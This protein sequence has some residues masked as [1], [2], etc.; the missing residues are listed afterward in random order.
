MSWIFPESKRSL[1]GKRWLNITMRSFH[2]VG[3]LGVG[4]GVVFGLPL[5]EW[6][7]F[8]WLMLVTGAI[9]ILTELW[10]SGIWLVQL[11][12]LATL[13]KLLLLLLIPFTHFDVL[14]L[15]IVVLLSSF[16]AHAPASIRYYSVWHRQVM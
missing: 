5:A 16:F 15:V 1:P 2:L 14:V 3:L 13:T 6:Q 12:G 8:F 4:G 11:R 9:M 7:L 10:T